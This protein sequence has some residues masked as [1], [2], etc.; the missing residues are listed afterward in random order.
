M[1]QMMPYLSKQTD[2]HFNRTIAQLRIPLKNKMLRLVDISE[3]N[4][5]VRTGPASISNF[6]LNTN[7]STLKFSNRQL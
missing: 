5:S 7:I 3:V 2:F 1:S 4:V 6:A